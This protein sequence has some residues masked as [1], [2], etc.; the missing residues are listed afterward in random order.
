MNE[1]NQKTQVAIRGVLTDIRSIPTQTGTA[2]VMCKVGQHKC[3]LFG[4]LAER[5]LANKHDHQGREVEARGHWDERR[6][7]EF[8]IE[9][10]KTGPIQTSI[11]I[12]KPV[13]D[14]RPA[15]P[16][17]KIKENYLVITIPQGV[18]PELLRRITDFG[19]E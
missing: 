14:S 9:G 13:D 17:M 19:N 12:Q 5:I 2:F 10:F 4:E 3:K 16:A 7:N 1:A 8:V 18:T 6:G 15:K 11:D